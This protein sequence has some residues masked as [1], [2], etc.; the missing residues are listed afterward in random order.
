MSSILRLCLCIGVVTLVAH[1]AQD[2]S[3]ED[4]DAEEPHAD[5]DDAEVED[6]DMK[7]DGDMKVALPAEAEQMEGLFGKIDADKDGKMSMPE[8]IAFW[9]VTRKGILHQSNAQDME[10]IDTDKDKKVSLEEY[11]K[12]EESEFLEA[13]QGAAD[14]AR[15][16]A[17]GDLHVAKFKAADKNSDGFL[18]EHELPDAVYG[19]THDE[20]VRI[21]AA[22]DLKMKDKDGDGKL[23][24]NEFNEIGEDPK[25]GDKIDAMEGAE[26]GEVGEKDAKMAEEEAMSEKEMAE[27]FKKQDADGDGKLNL[28]ELVHFESGVF[29]MTVDMKTLF[30]TCDQDKDSYITFKELTEHLH[31]LDGSAASDHLNEWAEHQDSLAT[32]GAEL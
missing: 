31:D 22:H 23:D 6:A 21:M 9:K 17:F 32:H 27:E 1:S 3:V 24:V 7:V 4:A 20:V 10:L 11:V 26:A 8:I 29:H 2:K 12:K 28:D 16:K 30:E 5:G 19:E 18:D 25:V 14:D 13:E 15:T